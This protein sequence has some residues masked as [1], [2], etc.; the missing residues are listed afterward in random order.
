MYTNTQ[1]QQWESCHILAVHLGLAFE[2]YGLTLCNLLEVWS[3]GP[4]T[5]LDKTQAWQ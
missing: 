3:P 4:P 1:I 5:P 2:V